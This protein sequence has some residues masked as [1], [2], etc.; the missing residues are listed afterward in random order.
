MMHSSASI[1]V[2]IGLLFIITS[3]STIRKDNGL[4][5]ITIHYDKVDDREVTTR[6]IKLRYHQKIHRHNLF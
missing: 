5:S 2:G 1:L 3:K 4:S 6:R